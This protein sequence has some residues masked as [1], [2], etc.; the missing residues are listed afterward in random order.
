MATPLILANARLLGSDALIDERP[1][2][3]VTDVVVEGRITEIRQGVA[4]A[5]AQRIDLDGRW[6]LPGLWDNHVHM[7]Q[8]TL[9]SR[10]ASV[11]DATSA[12]AVAAHVLA[13][14]PD[15][16]GIAIYAGARTGLWPDSPDKHMLT[17][18]YPIVVVSSDAHS[19]WLNQVALE[20]FGYSS[21]PTGILVEDDNFA[22]LTKLH[23]V[24]ETQLDSWVR[25]SAA[26]AAARGVVGIVDLEW[27]WNIGDW[28]RRE[29][30]GFD[31]LQVEAGFYAEHL[32]LALAEGWSTGQPA[33]RQLHCGPLKVIFDGSLGTRTA[34]CSQAY[35]DGSHGQLNLSE[36]DLELLVQRAAA[37]GIATT[38]H[39]IGDEANRIALDIFE[40]TGLTGTI[41]HAQQVCDDDICRF[42]ALGVVA[43]VQPEHA[44]DDRELVARY[45]ANA[46]GVYRLRSLHEAGATLQFGS[47]APV[48][49]L[50]PWFAIASAVTR[51]R[52]PELGAWRPDE[53]LSLTDAL[54]ASTRTLV[55]PGQRADLVVL[56][57]D[58]LPDRLRT[59]PIA[60]TLLGGRFTHCTL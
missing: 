48:T 53:A 7:G 28:R 58:L 49:P 46:D 12:A 39:A 55:A 2:G 19:M 17:A 40:R 38:V 42:A 50:D 33:G 23:D 15:E 44:M 56:D 34:F 31:L 35:P 3:D 16:T 60:A 57:D 21:H 29:A 20:R 25:Q 59:M 43:S 30:N 14:G 27:G 18:A 6:L 1:V 11:A 37:G 47:D 9:W 32:D 24:P 36:A 5:N 26:A 13:D 52:E 51:T 41:E 22:V 45:W 8:W 10:H 54:Q 4:S